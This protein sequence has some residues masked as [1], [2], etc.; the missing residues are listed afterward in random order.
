MLR[1]GSR[2]AADISRLCEPSGRGMGSD[3]STEG[4]E[5]VCWRLRKAVTV[6]II[7]LVEV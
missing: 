7:E 5:N 3:R 1:I 6:N 2:I 4:L